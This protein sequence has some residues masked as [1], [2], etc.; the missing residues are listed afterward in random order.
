MIGD[1]KQKLI[2]EEELEEIKKCWEQES[3]AM[4]KGMN[5]LII[6]EDIEGVLKLVDE[7]KRLN[8]QNHKLRKGLV[9]EKQK[10]EQY[11]KELEEVR[12]M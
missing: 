12:K 7:I 2:S 4:W 11:K 1:V 8:K 10:N 9:K 3:E 5:T 6:Q